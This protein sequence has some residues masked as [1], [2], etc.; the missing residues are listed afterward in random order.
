MLNDNDKLNLLSFVREVSQVLLALLLGPVI[1]EV[2][3]L[4][5]KWKCV[6]PK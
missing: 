1:N 6:S 2:P 4:P 3:V 5:D